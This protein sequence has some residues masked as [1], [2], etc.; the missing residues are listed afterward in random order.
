MGPRLSQM[1]QR[2]LLPFLGAPGR[3]SPKPV[4]WLALGWA[5]L[6]THRESDERGPCAQEHQT[7]GQDRFPN[8]QA[9]QHRSMPWQLW[10]PRTAG[11]AFQQ[12]R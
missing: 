9:C 12:W 7:Y 2:G 10:E 6:G 3:D 4:L 8:H 1:N 5:L 11:E